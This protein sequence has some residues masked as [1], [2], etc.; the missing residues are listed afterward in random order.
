M[1]YVDVQGDFS[2]LS[3]MNAF[4]EKMIATQNVWLYGSTGEHAQSPVLLPTDFARLENDP[5]RSLAW[6]VRSNGGYEKLSVPFQ[7]FMYGNLFREN[8]LVPFPQQQD[9][10]GA[11]RVGGSYP[12]WTLCSSDPYNPTCF[13]SA[14]QNQSAVVN[15]A[16]PAAMKLARSSAA[17]GLPG[18]GGGSVK[19]PTCS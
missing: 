4:W 8:N 10:D 13:N 16:V 3:D 7:D 5:Y 14:G 6:L 15:A 12:S 11:G 19:P 18:Y 2:D 9:I 17:S 1:P